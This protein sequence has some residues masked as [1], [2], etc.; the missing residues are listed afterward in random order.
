MIRKFHEAKLN[1]NAAVVPLGYRDAYERISFV[2]DMAEAVVFCF[3][4]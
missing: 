2:D 1:D 4:K 3:R